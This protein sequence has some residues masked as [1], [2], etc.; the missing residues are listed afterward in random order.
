[1]PTT[2]TIEPLGSNETLRTLV[3]VTDNEVIEALTLERDELQGRVDALTEE[4]TNLQ[5]E[6]HTLQD[7]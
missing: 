5:T 3:L 4:N 7:A 6:L 1:M 2:E